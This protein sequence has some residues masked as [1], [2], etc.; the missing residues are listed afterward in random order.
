MAFTG[1]SGTITLT[2]GSTS[3]NIG[4]I[5]ALEFDSEFGKQ[6]RVVLVPVNA[7]AVN[8]AVFV[9]QDDVSSTGFT[10]SATAALLPNGEYQYNYL[11]IE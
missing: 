8:T 3:L 9:A 2:T 1:S 11:V 7:A 10:L 4:D 5:L 6:P